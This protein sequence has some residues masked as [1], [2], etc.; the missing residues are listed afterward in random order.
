M[1][2]NIPKDLK[3]N[4]DRA[5]APQLLKVPLTSVQRL[6]VFNTCFA[7][8]QSGM[9]PRLNFTE[10]A[11]GRTFRRTMLAM[12]IVPIRDVVMV[13][14]HKVRDEQ[15]KAGRR[16]HTLTRDQVDF[17]LT[18]VAVLERSAA[19]E[20]NIGEVLDVL[21][22]ALRDGDAA[23]WLAGSAPAIPDYD[24]RDEDWDGGAPQPDD[25]A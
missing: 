7:F 24:A 25:A 17:V 12:G 8:D 19:A 9:R 1:K 21:R 13:L 6:E 16:L 10:E 3:D 18:H 2:A 22:E 11:L 14:R 23:S 15:V 20:M 4:V 5:L